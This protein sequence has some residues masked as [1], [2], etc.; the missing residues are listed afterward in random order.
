MNALSIPLYNPFAA[1]YDKW[2]TWIFATTDSDDE[3]DQDTFNGEESFDADFDADTSDDDDDGDDDEG[4]SSDD[5]DDQQG[6]DDEG[7]KES[8]QRQ[9]AHW[10]E[11]ANKLK[12]ELEQLRGTDKKDKTD[13]EK[14]AE[15]YIETVVSRLMKAREAEREAAEAEKQAERQEALE[16][17]LTENK[18]IK[19][20]DVTALMEEL[21]LTPQQAVA[22]LKRQPKQ[23]KKPQVPKPKRGKDTVDTDKKD[24]APTSFEEATQRAR[25]FIRKI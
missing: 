8:L 25:E 12:Q 17:V 18:G 7:S 13:E 6:K 19:E 16:E 10:R 9:K 23:A 24:K 21:D 20:A 22:V 15:S 4:A 11:K 14:R 2:L 3:S 5:D 1:L